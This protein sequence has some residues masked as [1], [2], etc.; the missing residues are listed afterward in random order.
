VAVALQVDV[1]LRYRFLRRGKDC[2]EILD[3]DRHCSGELLFGGSASPGIPAIIHQTFSS[4]EQLPEEV[5]RNI[6]NTRALNP[7]YDYRFYD[8]T[9]VCNFIES[10]YG[11]SMLNVFQAVNGKYGGPRA[12]LFR[13]LLVYALGGV[14][15]DIKAQVTR[16]FR[17]LLRTQDHYILS[18]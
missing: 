5:K 8:D 15:L 11:P 3:F 17:E 13:Y 18:Q 7:D 10:T 6:A 12:D 14:Y 2:P 1:T 16:P 4:F 9:M